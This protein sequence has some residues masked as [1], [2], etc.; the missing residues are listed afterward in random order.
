MGGGREVSVSSHIHAKEEEEESCDDVCSFTAWRS[1][2]LMLKMGNT[3]AAS[4]EH[5]KAQLS[6]KKTALDGIIYT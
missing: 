2:R 4:P 5:N 1:C 3:A 6:A